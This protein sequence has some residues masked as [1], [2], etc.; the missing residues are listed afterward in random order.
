M[1]IIAVLSL[2]VPQVKGEEPLGNVLEFYGGND[3]K[4]R[5][6]L[7]F[8]REDDDQTRGL[9]FKQELTKLNKHVRGNYVVLNRTSEPNLD[10][11]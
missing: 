11:E 10:D 7:D 2:F 3:S 9:D 6:E 4:M 1:I 5:N 8:M